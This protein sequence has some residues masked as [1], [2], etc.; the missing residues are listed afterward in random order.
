MARK[1][2]AEYKLQEKWDETSFAKKFSMRA[3]RAG[4][5]DFDRFKVMISKKNRIINSL[6]MTVGEVKYVQIAVTANAAAPFTPDAFTDTQDGRGITWGLC[7]FINAGT[8][9]KRHS[10][11]ARFDC[12]LSLDVHDPALKRTHIW[13]SN[14]H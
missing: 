2:A 13:H 4:L 9:G 1:A 8:R 12:D 14:W 3:K 10:I 11:M 6:T 5:N 7:H